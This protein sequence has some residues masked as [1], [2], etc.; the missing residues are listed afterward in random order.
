MVNIRGRGGVGGTQ[1]F[2]TLPY[3]LPALRNKD[4]MFKATE[5]SHL[6]TCMTLQRMY[7]SADRCT[8]LV[9]GGK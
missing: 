8:E 2:I 5:F 9:T 1:K 6:L 3:K 7:Q 4:L